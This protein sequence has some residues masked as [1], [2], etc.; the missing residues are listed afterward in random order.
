MASIERHE[1]AVTLH[2]DRDDAVKVTLRLAEIDLAVLRDL[3]IGEA[4]RAEV[5]GAG[6][7]LDPCCRPDTKELGEHEVGVALDGHE[8]QVVRVI[9][10]LVHP[11]GPAFAAFELSDERDGT[12]V[13]GVTIV[14]ASEPVPDTPPAPDPQRPC[15][16]V[17]GSP[18]RTL[19]PLSPPDDKGAGS[20][21]GRE[22]REQLVAEVVNP[23]GDTLEDVVVHLEH[24]GG[25]AF[26]GPVYNVGTMA[27]GDRFLCVWEVDNG[28]GAP[29]DY[30]AS[31]VVQAAKYE[32]VRQRESIRLIDPRRW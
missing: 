17:L 15:P 3:G 1:Q 9:V 23:T 19:G 32:P 4:R 31:V 10:D 18:L 2:N 13:G 21:L 16:V 8:T 11:G 6:I 24:L 14:A 22:S 30:P 29:D 25:L 28:S 27:P 5:A 26:D 7:V 12:I 20:V